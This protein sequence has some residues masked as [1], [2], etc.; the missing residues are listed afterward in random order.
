MPEVFGG[1]QL[2]VRQERISLIATLKVLSEDGIR[3]NF[4]RENKE[5]SRTN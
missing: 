4:V 2:S 5:N 1:A 3:C